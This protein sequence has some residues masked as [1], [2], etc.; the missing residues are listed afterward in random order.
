MTPSA[1]P[2]SLLHGSIVGRF[3]L[4]KDDLSDHLPIVSSFQAASVKRDGS[5][6]PMEIDFVCEGDHE[7]LNLEED[8]QLG[9]DDGP[10][11][12][13]HGIA[14][15]W[16]C[17]TQRKVPS[18][19]IQRRAELLAGLHHDQPLR[20]LPA[21]VRSELKSEARKHLLVDALPSRRS[22]PFL[23]RDKQVLVVGQRAPS[24]ELRAILSRGYGPLVLDPVIWSP[25]PEWPIQ[26]AQDEA[27]LGWSTLQVLILKLLATRGPEISAT[28]HI[29]KL[30]AQA[31][32]IKVQFAGLTQLDAAKSQLSHL[33]DLCSGGEALDLKHL[34]IK[35]WH[36]GDEVLLEADSHGL[37]KMRPG[38]SSGGFLH[39]RMA[40]RIDQGLEAAGLFRSMLMRELETGL[41]KG[42]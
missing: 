40:R 37:T 28:I 2:P 15:G 7:Q 39:E 35:V 6:A 19:E 13:H 21:N 18:S 23:L 30:K 27:A 34:E 42:E 12:V 14:R 17:V 10:W 1:L 36:Q 26:V 38:R 3:Y 32:G 5:P 33:L 41:R 31:A 22:M 4:A 11:S 9:L 25:R 24:N 8:T 20:R 16:V 29:T